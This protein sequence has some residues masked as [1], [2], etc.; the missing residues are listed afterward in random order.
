MAM[1]LID[2]C[3]GSYA[4]FW[5]SRKLYFAFA[6]LPMAVK[7]VF[8]ALVPVLGLTHEYV[9]TVL[10]LIPAM[11]VE[12]WLVVRVVRYALFSEVFPPL[13]DPQVRRAVTGGI[14]LYVLIALFHAGLQ[15]VIFG[16]MPEAAGTTAQNAEFSGEL[17][18]PPPDGVSRYLF[19]AGALALIGGF[20][21]LFR[22]FWVYV[23]AA[24]GQS[25]RA[26]LADLPAFRTSL[27][28]FGAWIFCLMPFLMCVL[29]ALNLLVIILGN[30]FPPE[31]L[32]FGLSLIPGVAF[33]LFSIIMTLCVTRL[34]QALYKEKEDRDHSRS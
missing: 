31:P 4:A 22:L 13:A 18:P 25:V 7:T 19:M 15:A 23:P 10:F 9:W 33:T 16:V 20:I 27:L 30:V 1:D 21:W 17:P 26:F 12:G 28:M 24:A 8:L 3:A 29:I 32:T 6:L 11:F 5:R 2:V 14:L 34:I